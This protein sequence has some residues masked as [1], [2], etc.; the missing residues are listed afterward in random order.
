MSPEE[1]EAVQAELERLQREAMVC[2]T[3]TEGSS[4]C[5]QPSVPMA[6][7]PSR[8]AV[9][10]PAVPTNEPIASESVTKTE[11]TKGQFDTTSIA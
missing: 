7:E 10:L 4:S 5:P 3:E 11:A 8:E 9:E 6:V 2:Q 1:E